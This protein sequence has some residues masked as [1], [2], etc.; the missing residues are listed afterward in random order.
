[1]DV[2]FVGWRFETLGIEYLSACLKRKGHSVKLYFD[3]SLFYDD[4]FF[5]SK[6]MHGIFDTT[7]SLVRRIV[8]DSPE[9]LCFSVQAGN[10]AWACDIASRVK[11][12]KDIPV[13]FGG[14]HPTSVPETVLGKDFIDYICIGEGEEA[15]PELLN[16]MKSKSSLVGVGNIWFKK[17]HE[18]VKNFIRPLIDD[19]DVLPLPDKEIFYNECRHIINGVYV[20]MASRGCYYCCTYCCHDLLNRIYPDNRGRVR[21]RGVEQLMLELRIAKNK[22]RPR[23]L[24]FNDD[25]FPS[26]Q[27]W[28]REFASRYRQEIGLPFGINTHIMQINEKYVA[29]LVRAGCASVDIGIQSV[30]MGVR[31]C[32]LN[33]KMDNKKISG[34]I[35][36]LKSQNL[37]VYIDLML[38]LPGESKDSL[39]QSLSAIREW[40]PDG[41]ASLFLSYFPNTTLTDRAYASGIISEERMK[42][43]RDPVSGSRSFV[44]GGDVGSKT[45]MCFAAYY[46][47]ALFLPG[48]LLDFLVESNFLKF[49]PSVFILRFFA[50]FIGFV[51]RFVVYLFEKR[52]R[53]FR[54][55]LRKEIL[56]YLT[57]LSRYI[58]GA[59]RR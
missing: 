47:F 9:L 5:F 4:H 32:I 37:Y 17:N 43:I 41:I 24:Y 15:L 57:Y 12:M 20:T 40:K 50:H 56:F 18:I 10:Y 58:Y 46:Q 51:R 8:S 52:L 3:P 33:R 22:Y 6:R 11:L 19:L 38:G 31:E 2:G 45:L 49:L 48:R 55:S 26:K 44:S 54:F 25:V 1:M 34:A 27:D 16:K 23:W 21:I 36:M 35:G 14:I 39:K 53:C 7:E 29:E 28:L 13:I 30:D 42:E 59:G